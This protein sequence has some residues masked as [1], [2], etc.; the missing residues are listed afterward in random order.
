MSIQ[1]RAFFF[2]LTAVLFVAM[3][4]LA[5]WGFVAQQIILG[6]CCIMIAAAFSYFRLW[7]YSILFRVQKWNPS[8]S[9]ICMFWENTSSPTMLP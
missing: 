7:R 8:E 5:V 4:V 9:L 6:V 3:L 1:L 2:I